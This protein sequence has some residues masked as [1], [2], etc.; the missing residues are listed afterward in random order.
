MPHNAAFHLGLHCS[1]AIRLGYQVYKE[2]GNKG[3]SLCT[4]YAEVIKE[5]P[6][7]LVEQFSQEMVIKC[8]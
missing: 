2:L 7:I 8:N 3:E 1:Q 4:Q 6:A 5:N